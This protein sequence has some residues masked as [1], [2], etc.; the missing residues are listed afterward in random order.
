MALQ[1][2]KI[3]SSGFT[4]NYWKITTINV[5]RMGNNVAWYLSLFKDQETS[6]SGKP[7]LTKSFQGSLEDID[8]TS[9]LLSSGYIFIKLEIG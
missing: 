4:A 6:V 9:N 3:L 8:P 1:K 7:V 2:N 5:N